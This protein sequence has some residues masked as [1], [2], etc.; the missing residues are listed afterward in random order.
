MISTI[1][2]YQDTKQKFADILRDDSQTKPTNSQTTIG[3]TLT[4]R[5]KMF[6]APQSSDGGKFGMS[7]VYLLHPSALANE[8]SVAQTVY[9]L[10]KTKVMT[11][12]LA[13]LNR[14]IPS[15]D[16]AAPV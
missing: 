5:K 9:D 16:G 6:T 1:P 7:P 14:L 4:M 8:V 12:E 13:Y 15:I 2:G 10:A 3:F 11:E